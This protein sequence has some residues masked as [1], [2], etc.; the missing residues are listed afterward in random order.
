MN[1]QMILV[2]VTFA[3]REDQNVRKLGTRDF[4]VKRGSECHCCPVVVVWTKN[5][6]WLSNQLPNLLTQ[7]TKNKL[8]I[9]EIK[10]SLVDAQWN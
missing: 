2:H 10:K 5:E 3:W 1:T 7:E 4:H 6:S 9:E 8:F